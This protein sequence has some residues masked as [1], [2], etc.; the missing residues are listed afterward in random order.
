[1]T[2]VGD[3]SNDP[4]D[5]AF[6]NDGSQP[7][8]VTITTPEDESSVPMQIE[9]DPTNVEAVEVTFVLEDGTN[10]TVVSRKKK[11]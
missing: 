1:M 5:N 8:T 10:E 3:T 11:P 7:I 6:S 2:S 4:D 9:V